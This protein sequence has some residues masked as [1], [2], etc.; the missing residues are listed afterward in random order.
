[1]TPAAS[2]L[3][4]AIFTPTGSGLAWSGSAGLGGATG[5]GGGLAAGGR[6]GGGGGDGGLGWLKHIS[7][8]PIVV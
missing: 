7:L 5:G 3:L 1:M 6:G 4:F 8:L 2:R